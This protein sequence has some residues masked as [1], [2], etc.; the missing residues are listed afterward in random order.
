MQIEVRINVI[1][2]TIR[3]NV[4][5]TDKIGYVKKNIRKET[6]KQQGVDIPE[7]EMYPLFNKHTS[8]I[9]PKILD[10]DDKTLGDYNYSGEPLTVS[11]TPL[12]N[13]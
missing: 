9:T 10:D 8:I 7:N 5:N 12:S 1:N 3:L 11:P 4:K 2:R 6:K 13:M